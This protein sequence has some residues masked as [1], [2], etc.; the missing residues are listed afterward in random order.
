MRKGDFHLS[1]IHN[2]NQL[3]A[4]FEEQFGGNA[5]M[6]LLSAA[7]GSEKIYVHIDKIPPGQ[8]STKYHSHSKQEE[9]F[10]ILAGEGTLRLDGEQYPVKKGDFF[11]KPAGKNIA[12]QFINTGDAILE[13]LDVGTKEQGDIAHYP[14]EDVYFLRDQ[15]LVFRG[16]DA[17]KGWSSDPNE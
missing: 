6:L 12:H 2:L 10:L 17:E 4:E 7:A 13:I 1:Q 11:A 8:K 9:F 15:K 14:D 3:P 5:S 16:E